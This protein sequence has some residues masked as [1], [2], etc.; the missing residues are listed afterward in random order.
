MRVGTVSTVCFLLS[1]T[2]DPHPAVA[3]SD[4]ASSQP[5][6]VSQANPSSAKPSEPAKRGGTAGVL[7]RTDPGHERTNPRLWSF[8]QGKGVVLSGVPQLEVLQCGHIVIFKAPNMDSEIIQAVPRN[9]SDQM[10]TFRALPPCC[11]D[12]TTAVG[13][14][15][16]QLIPIPPGTLLQPKNR[17]PAP[18]LETFKKLRP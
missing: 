15:D 11:R 4:P 2:C 8:S 9:F 14:P 13:P 12:F 3:Q 7:L 17:A 18:D 6:Q 1:L 5:P 10:P 16:L